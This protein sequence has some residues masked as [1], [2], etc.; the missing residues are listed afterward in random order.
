[1]KQFLSN[2]QKVWLT[3][4]TRCAVNPNELLWNLMKQQSFEVKSRFWQTMR[5]WRIFSLF[6]FLSKPCSGRPC[7]NPFYILIK[8]VLYN[9]HWI[10]FHLHMVAWNKLIWLFVIYR[11][12]LING[13]RRWQRSLFTICC[14]T[15]FKHENINHPMLLCTGCK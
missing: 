12:F 9:R 15:P 8:L 14:L 3:H 1:M 6:F 11:V 7:D 4:E 10:Q 13:L 2:L 5:L